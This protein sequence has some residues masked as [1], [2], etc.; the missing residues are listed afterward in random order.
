MPEAS[1]GLIMIVR[2]EAAN[3]GRSLGPVASC[4]DEVVAIDTGSSDDTVKICRE[5]GAKVFELTWQD[6]FAAARNYSIAKATA[7]WLFWLDGDNAITPEMVAELRIKLSQ[8]PAVLW[9]LEVIEQKGGQL[10][11]KRCFPRC[12]EA[13]FAGRV[14]E[15]LVHPPHWPSIATA[16]QVR[17]WGYVDHD[18]AQ[19]KGRYYLH[20]LKQMLV[21]DPE[22]FYASFQLGRTYYNLR[23]FSSSIEHFMA[24]IKSAQARIAN[25]QTWAH[26][27]FYLAHAYERLASFAEAEQ[28]L[29][30]MLLEWPE[31]G[32][33]HYHRGRL[34]YA[35]QEWE[36]AAKHFALALD[37]GLDK[38]FI[39]IDP[40]K[41]LFLAE[42]YLG[43]CYERLGKVL[44]ART[45]LESAA[46][47]QPHNPAPRT[48][49]ARLLLSQGQATEA[50]AYLK[51]IL[52][53]RPGDRAARRLLAESEAL[54]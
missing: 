29:D 7:D 21:D 48:D 4:F 8:G 11:Q 37:L 25:P 39:D 38:P 40:A 43:R 18:H 5:F 49:L 23:Y 13:Y 9:A 46:L 6:D 16:V 42:Y 15:Q 22:D 31:N 53:Q 28:V 36:A 3:L 52:K 50:K 19:T 10:W 47:K 12:P 35:C 41:T 34:A 32:L 24:V 20:L 27:N 14:H 33:G 44:E 1:L 26:A 51:Q 45:A 17:H 2:S 30:Q 54:A